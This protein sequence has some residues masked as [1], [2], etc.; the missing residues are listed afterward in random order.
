MAQMRLAP[1]DLL[2]APAAIASRLA[3]VFVCD[4]TPPLIGLLR[5]TAAARFAASIL[6][7]HQTMIGLAIA[8]EE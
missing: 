2:G 1:P 4:C 7:S 5:L 3:A 6:C 8:T